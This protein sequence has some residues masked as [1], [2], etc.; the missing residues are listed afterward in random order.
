MKTPKNDYLLRLF[1][2]TDELRPQFMHANNCDGIIYATNTY[3]LAK[4]SANMC[5]KSY[6]QIKAWPNGNILFEQFNLKESFSIS[7]ESIFNDLIKIE[8]LFKNKMVDCNE[9]NGD[10]T[11]ICEHCDSEHDCKECCGSGEIKSHEMILSGDADCILFGR[12][13][14]LSAIDKIIRVATTLSVIDITIDHNESGS[15]SIFKIGD[16]TILAMCKFDL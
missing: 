13:Y 14:S 7:T 2:G 12:K 8:L 16:F 3:L 4:I 1:I 15:S 5:C 9:C 11:L 10:G 6:E